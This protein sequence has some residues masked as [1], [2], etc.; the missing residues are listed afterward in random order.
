MIE[1]AW[2]AVCSGCGWVYAQTA[3][4]HPAGVAE[5]AVDELCPRCGVDEKQIFLLSEEDMQRSVWLP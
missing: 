2:A 3:S 4:E 5:A 1:F